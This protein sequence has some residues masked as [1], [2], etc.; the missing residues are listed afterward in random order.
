MIERETEYRSFLKIHLEVMRV[1][2]IDYVRIQI[3]NT[4]VFSDKNDI[5]RHFLKLISLKSN[6]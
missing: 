1:F 2:N 5:S 6:R 4:L 3:I